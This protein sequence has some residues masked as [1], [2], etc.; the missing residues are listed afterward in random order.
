[1]VKL[2]S[3]YERVYDVRASPDDDIKGQILSNSEDMGQKVFICDSKS[4]RVIRSTIRWDDKCQDCNKSHL[5]VIE[6]PSDWIGKKVYIRPF[7]I[8]RM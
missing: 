6:L 8:V 2:G 7:E 4:S 5:G 1:V 3:V